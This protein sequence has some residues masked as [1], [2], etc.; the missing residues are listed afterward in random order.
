[1]NAKT[2]AILSMAAGITV[3]LFVKNTVRS[4]MDAINDPEIR[5]TKF[6]NALN[7]GVSIFTAAMW[8]DITVDTMDKI[9]ESF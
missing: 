7:E 3:G 4:G 5:N 8:I 9:L 1:M 6:R 2:K